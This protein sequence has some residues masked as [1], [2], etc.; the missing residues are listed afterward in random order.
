M[1]GSFYF[2]FL[3]A[4][5]IFSA[6]LLYMEQ[7]HRVDLRRADRLRRDAEDRAEQAS[8][9]AALARADLEVVRG[10]VRNLS[11]RGDPV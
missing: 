9:S 6:A 8:R 7:R 5:L 2:G 1:T 4:S 10:A 11:M 3:T